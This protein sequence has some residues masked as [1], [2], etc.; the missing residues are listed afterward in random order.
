MTSPLNINLIIPFNDNKGMRLKLYR[1][2][3]EAFRDNLDSRVVEIREE[4]QS[5]FGDGFELNISPRSDG[6]SKKYYWRFKSAKRDRK[7]NRLQAE[8]V[9]SY[10]LPFGDERWQRVKSIEEELIYVNANL[11]LIKGMLDAIDQSEEELS[12]FRQNLP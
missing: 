1:R 7:Y 11:K 9:R 10:L 8:S 6:N 2:E 12:S 5:L 3:I 4:L